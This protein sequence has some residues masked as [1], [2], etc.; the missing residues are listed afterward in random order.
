MLQGTVSREQETCLPSAGARVPEGFKH[1]RVIL[2]L[3]YR[4]VILS[5]VKRI[6]SGLQN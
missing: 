3:K 5:S 1:R 2:N 6:T 4:N